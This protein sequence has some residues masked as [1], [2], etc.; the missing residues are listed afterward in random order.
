[1]TWADFLETNASRYLEAKQ[2]RD[3]GLSWEDVLATWHKGDDLLWAADVR[4]IAAGGND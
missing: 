1:M 3:A 4:D 2:W